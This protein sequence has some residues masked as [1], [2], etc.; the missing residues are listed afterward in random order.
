[1]AQCDR[2]L[3]NRQRDKLTMVAE[4]KFKVSEKDLVAFNL[5]HAKNSKTFRNRIRWAQIFIA[6]IIIIVV[7]I[8]IITQRYLGVFFTVIIGT[9]YLL[10]IPRIF[11][12]FLD[13]SAKKLLSEGPNEGILGE[14]LL[15]AGGE[16]LSITN[17]SG[18][19]KLNWPAITK[20][21]KNERYFFLYVSA[22]SAI[23]IPKETVT[24]GDLSGFISVVEENRGI[25]P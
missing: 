5:F 24:F 19:T 1:M 16:G 20:I 15:S 4:I 14:H 25:A 13:R 11:T 12:F 21:A 7:T 22:I 23:V 18:E 9:T 8:E 10:L 2:G 6:L 3:T 17:T